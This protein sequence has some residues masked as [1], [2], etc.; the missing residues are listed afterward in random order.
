MKKSVLALALVALGMSAAFAGEACTGKGDCP[1]H[2]GSPP[3]A[4]EGHRMD[5]AKFP[6]MKAK[7]LAHT[8]EHQAC[9]EAA[10]S[11]DELRNCKPKRP[12]GE[13]RGERKP[14]GEPGP[15]AERGAPPPGR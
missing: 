1:C 14:R 10:Q 8:K 9:V 6:E 11:A 12:E 2:D 3:F 15:G 4:R 5:P 13:G 7:I